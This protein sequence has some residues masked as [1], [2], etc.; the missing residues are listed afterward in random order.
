MWISMQLAL[1]VMAI[2]ATTVPG[3][4]DT[5]EARALRQIDAI[6]MAWRIDREI[7][8]ASGDKICLVISLGRDVI[9]RLSKEPRAK[10]A[11]W[12]VTIGFDNQPGSLRY[13][14][15]NKT[16]FQTDKDSF[17]GTE[18]KEIVALLKS[19]GEF[20]FEW[21]KRPDYAKRP[22]LFGNGDF[23]AKAAE[24]DRWMTGTRV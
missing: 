5:D 16:I 1:A 10:T 23:A 22:G 20:A 2:V 19:P 15:I 18:A 13:L 24:C 17:R 21:A 11:A 9:A 8:A 7:G 12:S 14:R 6:A 3:P 4:P